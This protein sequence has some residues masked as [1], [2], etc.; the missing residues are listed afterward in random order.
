MDVLVF[1]DADMKP[2]KIVTPR[3]GRNG[4]VPRAG[5]RYAVVAHRIRSNF[6]RFILRFYSFN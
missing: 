4:E 2:V 1:S 6:Y 3:S 5:E